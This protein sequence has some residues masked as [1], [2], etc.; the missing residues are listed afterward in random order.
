M[1][2]EKG[3]LGG[4][5]HDPQGPDG[6]TKGAA[7]GVPAP[8]ALAQAQAQTPAQTKSHAP[9]RELSA[10]L[11]ARLRRRRTAY[12]L[13]LSLGELVASDLA[14][15][16]RIE[17]YS[18]APHAT[19]PTIDRLPDILGSGRSCLLLGEPGAG[20]TLVLYRAAL[21]CEAAGLVPIV[22][23]AGD[24]DQLGADPAWQAVTQGPPGPVVV[25]LDGLD[26]A[27]AAWSLERGLPRVLT[28]TLSRFPCL[29]TSRTR[30]F[31]N[32]AVLHQAD[33]VF[34][35]IYQLRPWSVRTEFKDYLE[36][37]GRAGHIVKPRMYET[38]VDSEELSR[39]VS[40]PLHA[41][42][43]TF[44]GEEDVSRFADPIA[45]YGEYVAKLARIADSDLGRRSSA[46]DCGALRLWRRF[47]WEVHRHGSHAE[48]AVALG[49]LEEALSDVGPVRAVGGALDY[50]LDRRQTA[51]QEVGEFIHY[52]FYEYLMAGHVAEVLIGRAEPESIVEVCR[53]DLSREIRHFL[54]GQ[55]RAT[56]SA[57]VSRSL[58][59]SYLH[60]RKSNDLTRSEI[61]IVCNLIGYVLSRTT[62]SCAP[63]LRDLLAD[64]D[65]P[66]L[67]MSLLWALCHVGDLP[68]FTEFCG[69]LESS[70]YVRELARGYV[71]Y[72]YGDLP[73]DTEPPYRDTEPHRPLSLTPGRVLRLFNQP[74]FAT[75]VQ[76]ARQFVDIYALVDVIG[77]R[78]LPLQKN[79]K[80]RLLTLTEGMS[81]SGIGEGLITH[82]AAMISDLRLVQE[83]W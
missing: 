18:L 20:K 37:L 26:E 52:S 28:E 67:R 6:A 48:T 30:D 35:E 75:T 40:R 72:Y 74:G 49:P 4:D 63:A 5:P 9:A 10:L 36:R 24:I 25:L 65:E 23:R 31:E 78:G 11:L 59:N 39:L 45:L 50:I 79:D 83:D 60:A 64:E 7:P 57:E 29:V 66:F 19:G 27:L 43:L 81:G 8:G 34:D 68:A 12:P 56:P 2:G 21:A 14:V 73:R 54:I 41:R 80:V 55:L 44:V 42:M 53:V 51:G 15:D 62:D 47:A 58:V 22:L 13:D 46:V 77:V 17:R 16:T 76:P 38:V 61:L 33:V 70:A 69:Y 71:L 3:L 82:L 32:S 1:L